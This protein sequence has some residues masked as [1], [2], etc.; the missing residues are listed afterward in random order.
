MIDPAAFRTA[1]RERWETAAAGWEARR[2]ELQA[3]AEPVSRWLVDAI[4]PQPGQ[5][6]LELAAGLGDTGFLAAERIRPGGKLICTDGAEP[7]L[8]AA[9]RRAEALGLDNVEFEAMEAE[10]IDAQTATIDGV[11]CRWGYMLLA[12]PEAALRETRRVLK[13]GGRVALAAWDG[14]EHNPWVAQ[15]GA[16]LA[17][18][19]LVPP[20]SE[21]EPT[22]FSFAGEGV[23]EELLLTAGFEDVEVGAVD[24]VFRPAS[25]DEW[26]EYLFDM[27]PSLPEALARAA[28]EQRDE[29]YEGVAARLAAYRQDDG[30]LALPGRTLVARAS[31]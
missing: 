23:I 6:V 18:R 15:T 31:A 16:E 25:F 26:W 24:L 2:A 28:P 27:S 9:R 4:D 19:G 13:P 8:E 17:A 21:G 11:L 30:S 10:W 14:P 29:V 20:P 1:S 22:M 7:M 12:D 3:A 5:T